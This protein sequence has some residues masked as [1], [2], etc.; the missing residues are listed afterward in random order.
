M[1]DEFK[2]PCRD[3]ILKHNE[4][5]L[6]LV[7]IGFKFNEYNNMWVLILDDTTNDARMNEIQKIID[8]CHMCINQN[9]ASRKSYKTQK[10]ATTSM[11]YSISK[12]LDINIVGSEISKT[13]STS[14]SGTTSIQSEFT[15]NHS[16]M[17][18]SKLSSEPTIMEEP[19]YSSHNLNNTR[20]VHNINSETNMDSNVD[21]D[22]DDDNENNA[23]FGVNM[24]EHLREI[25]LIVTSQVNNVS[26]V[27][28]LIDSVLLTF[29]YF[30][31][32]SVLLTELES[33]FFNESKSKHNRK[34][35]SYFPEFGI[36]TEINN[37]INSEFEC[38]NDYDFD[39]T[40][41]NYI[42]IDIFSQ[43]KVIHILKKWIKQYWREDWKN[44]NDLLKQVNIFL[45]RIQNEYQNS[46]LC[47]KE[48]NKR[49]S[50]VTNI[51]NCIRIQQ[52]THDSTV[53]KE[54]VLIPQPNREILF[55]DKP[56]KLFDNTEVAKQ[57]TLID[58]S[59]YSLIRYI[60]S[61][62]IYVY[63]YFDVFRL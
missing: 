7:I 50:F 59:M 43:T 11:T 39:D 41:H 60:V 16:N 40:N 54:S 31:K 52:S 57:L 27:Y 18:S 51:K 17:N 32:A 30:T 34:S 63:V 37:D 33:R 13:R 46:D 4:I 35:I 20:R 42:N 3:P 38:K 48:I 45:D 61:S 49:L 22:M 53:A 9:R 6:I 26:K 24:D 25:I 2:I 36:H 56:F 1:L 23:V 62:L 10:R 14:I 47:V 58:F 8:D 29:P 19:S 28:D 15:F 12:T 55:K 21:V 44:N 5:K